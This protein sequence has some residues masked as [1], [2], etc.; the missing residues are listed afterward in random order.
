MEANSMKRIFSLFLA[1]LLMFGIFLTVPA[2]YADAIDSVNVVVYDADGQ[3]IWSGTAP[4]GDQVVAWL[5]ANVTEHIAKDGYTVDKWYSKDSGTK[6]DKAATFN[7]WTNVMVKYQANEVEAPEDPEPEMYVDVILNEKTSDFVSDDYHRC[8]LVNG[9]ISQSDIEYISARTKNKSIIGWSCVV[10]GVTARVDALSTFVFSSLRTPINIYP[11]FNATAS[12]STPNK[13]PYKAYLHIFTDNK[14]DEPAKNINITNGIAL[15]GR[16]TLSEVKSLVK[17]YYTA[18]TSDG[19]AYD[20][21]YL[22]TGNWVGDFVR[23]EKVDTI[24]ITEDL[25]QGYVHINVMINNAKL[26]NATAKVNDIPKTGDNSPVFAVSMVAVI[27]AIG[28]IVAIPM[29]RYYLVNFKKH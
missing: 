10:D 26:I 27:A 6:F 25:Q 23:D 4:K 22:A 2:A 13:F 9:K 28:L 29:K 8:V 16:V 11:I 18:K 12:D 3:E 21:L 24:E 1:A 19:I 14:V 15:D 5:D 7:G 20:G 17:T